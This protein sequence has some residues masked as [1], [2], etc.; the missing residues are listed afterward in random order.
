MASMCNASHDGRFIAPH[1]TTLC[2]DTSSITV[3]LS[4]QAVRNAE[5][6]LFKIEDIK[7]GVRYRKD[8]G[9]L[10]AL[11]TSIRLKGLIEP[12]VV[13]RTMTL[14]AGGRRIKACQDLGYTEIPTYFID[15]LTDLE[16]REI[17]LE[18]NLQR[19][20]MGHVEVDKLRTEIH[21]IRQERYGAAQLGQGKANLSDP[22]RK[23]SVADTAEKLN[24]DKSTVHRSMARTHAYAIMPS[25]EQTKSAKE[26]DRKINA[27]IEDL[28]REL[29][30]RQRA[31]QVREAEDHNR[32]I[33]GDACEE[34]SKLDPL[35]V[36]CCILDPP[37]GV[38]MGKNTGWRAEPA[39]DDD[40]VSAL[41]LIRAMLKE[42]RRVM[43]PN[44]HLYLF[45]PSLYFQ[46]VMTYLTE[47]HFVPDDIPLIWV[48]DEHGTVGW[49]KRYAPSYEM[50]FFCSDGTRT[51]DHK[52][53]N[54]F[55]YPTDK[56]KEHPYQK[57]VQLIRE[58]LQMSTHEQ[59]TVLDLCGGSGSTSIAA[60]Q[61]GRYYVYIDNDQRSLDIAR[62]QLDGVQFK[63]H[64]TRPNP[65]PIPATQ[66]RP[67]IKKAGV[68]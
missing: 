44:S 56:I 52:R 41:A 53:I 59:E 39:F 49:D 42:L 31:K 50:F 45:F 37:Y 22:D 28:E 66:P 32:L 57:P 2:N 18:E 20:P 24:V 51:L 13:D 23:W 3:E 7:I 43:R 6:H 55:N 5:Y 47:S 30:L 67:I 16:R 1:P 63:S 38:D 48:K 68:I 35:S 33:L 40:P 17:E 62:V 60:K 19:I 15:E 58:L 46:H 4:R 14:V 27:I 9:D 61:L 21:R 29:V 12:I 36:D 25:L 65:A 10:R 64:C 26:V 34:L 11:C 54:V 8:M